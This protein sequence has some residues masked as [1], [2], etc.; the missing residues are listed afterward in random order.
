[1]NSRIIK[2]NIKKPR[3][4][5]LVFFLFSFSILFLPI[6]RKAQAWDPTFGF[7]AA[8]W[9][10]GLTEIKNKMEDTMLGTIR[11]EMRIF[12]VQEV[13]NSIN[14]ITG[15]EGIMG[16][17][18][19]QINS[20]SEFLIE[21]PG[22]FAVA[23]LEGF[24]SKATGGRSEA[25][26]VSK[27]KKI[28]AKNY[29][30]YQGTLID[31][32]TSEGFNTP[33]APR[34]LSDDRGAAYRRELKWMNQ[35][36]IEQKFADWSSAIQEPTFERNPRLMLSAA[37]LKTMDIYLDGN[38]IN[39][40]WSYISYKNRKLEQ[41]Y[42][43]K[44]TEYI[45]RALI[46]Q[47]FVTDNQAQARLL[48]NMYDETDVWDLKAVMGAKSPA[49]IAVYSAI[50]A[51]NSTLKDSIRNVR[52][53]YQKDLAAYREQILTKVRNEL[54]QYNPAEL[55]KDEINATD[56]M[57]NKFSTGDAYEYKNLTT[58]VEERNSERER[59]AEQILNGS[60]KDVKALN[61][62]GL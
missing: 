42:E 17:V 54:G 32:D 61:S 13:E 25:S 12:I 48:K 19:G 16:I 57:H 20:W 35:S 37:D 41:A 27:V 38:D 55:F 7:A 1:M 10:V 28:P 62:I 56:A 34:Y 2:N 39:N 50:L 31:Y 15:R 14:M 46:G 36:L 30:T 9:E 8:T 58:Q 33:S 40:P 29:S 26:Y 52:T 3:A 59:A 44:S 22:K 11:M 18:Q 49:E 51:V 4:K 60:V 47:G 53:S 21:A 24:L 23:N 43:R 5:F 45:L 6:G